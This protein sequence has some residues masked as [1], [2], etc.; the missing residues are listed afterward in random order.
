MD[1]IPGTSQALP[2]L[3]WPRAFFREKDLPLCTSSRAP[4]A[5]AEGQSLWGRKGDQSGKVGCGWKGKIEF[6]V[7]GTWDRSPIGPPMSPATPN[8]SQN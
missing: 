6:R 7:A 1:P 3:S 2:V 5:C 4:P 8:S